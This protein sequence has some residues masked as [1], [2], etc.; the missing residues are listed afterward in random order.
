MASPAA[1][2]RRRENRKAATAVVQAKE[3]R[4]FKRT[5]RLWTLEL[6]LRLCRWTFRTEDDTQIP[7]ICLRYEYWQL[8]RCGIDVMAPEWQLSYGMT[9]TD[10]G[11]S[12]PWHWWVNLHPKRREKIVAM[13]ML[14][15][16]PGIS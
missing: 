14:K 11:L 15:R 7:S 5:G 16:V 6:I 4:R 1:V 9:V 8:R 10:P 13:S 3:L 12:A 2:A